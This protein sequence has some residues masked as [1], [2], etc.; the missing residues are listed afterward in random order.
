M[1]DQLELYHHDRLPKALRGKTIPHPPPATDWALQARIEK[2]E[3]LALQKEE[4]A[5]HKKQRKERAIFRTQQK[6]KKINKTIKQ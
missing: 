5:L 4:F 2:V 1:A 6:K 3:S